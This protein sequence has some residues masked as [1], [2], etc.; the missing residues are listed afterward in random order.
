MTTSTHGHTINVALSGVL[1]SLRR[2]WT[3]RS[4]QN[5]HVLVG[6]DV[7]HVAVH[8]TA[9]MLAGGRLDTPFEGECHKAHRTMMRWR[10]V[11]LLAETIQQS[12]LDTAAAVS[13]GGR[14]PEKVRDLVI[15]NPPFV[16][17]TN[18]EA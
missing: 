15:M 6:L 4:E 2:S 5:G 3:T 17:S 9:A 18:M 10:S 11:H 16:R 8:L 1:G 12:F 14:S 7:L 13:A